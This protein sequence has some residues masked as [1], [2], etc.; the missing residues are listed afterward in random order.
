MSFEQFYDFVLVDRPVQD[1][2]VL[3][4]RHQDRAVVMGVGEQFDFVGLHEQLP[5]A[6]RTCSQE[7]VQGL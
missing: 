7:Y 5:V 6:L 4:G 3:L 1:E 2:V